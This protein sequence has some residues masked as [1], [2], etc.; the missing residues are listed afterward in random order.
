MGCSVLL[1]LNNRHSVMTASVST[2]SMNDKVGHA[3][4]ARIVGPY[5]L[6]GYEDADVRQACMDIYG[7]P[8]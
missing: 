4:L 1:I 7:R 5:C 3:M 6:A 8:A 2:G